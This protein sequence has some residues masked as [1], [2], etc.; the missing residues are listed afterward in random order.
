MKKI[1]LIAI[2]CITGFVANAAA[3]TWSSGELYAPNLD[4]SVSTTKASS[5]AGAWVATVALYSDKNCNE[6]VTGI[7]GNSSSKINAM[8]S[9]LTGTFG[10]A[11]FDVGKT[12][13]GILEL[14]YTTAAGVQTLKTGI[15]S[16]AI[17]STGNTTLNFKEAVSSASW[18]AVPEPTSG[19]LLLLGLS[20]L[21]LR[22][23]VA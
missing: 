20:S 4:G 1:I 14:T 21:A 10:G 11:T 3:F 15:A 8:T 16:I 2:I 18:T 19:L 17:K 9:A 23:K 12:Y 7:T 6:L 22:R 5:A 13:Y